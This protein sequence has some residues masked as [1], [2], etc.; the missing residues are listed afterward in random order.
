MLRSQDRIPQLA[1]SKRKAVRFG[2]RRD[3]RYRKE[4]ILR[5]LS[6]KLYG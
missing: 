2:Q 5:L 1:F 4:D 3:G 6:K